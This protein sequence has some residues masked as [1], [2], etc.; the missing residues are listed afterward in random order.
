MSK[1]LKISA[2][3]P[4]VLFIF[5]G[6]GCRAMKS[7]KLQPGGVVGVGSDR[8]MAH[9]TL[10]SSNGPRFIFTMTINKFHSVRA[11]SFPFR[12]TVGKL[13]EFHIRWI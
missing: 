13:P 5:Q 6:A 9:E 1:Y 12:N 7:A 2:I 11:V 10:N 4:N 3:K 8:H